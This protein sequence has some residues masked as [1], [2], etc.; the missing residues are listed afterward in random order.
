VT[1]WTF[2]AG[3]PAVR[4]LATQQ[5]YSAVAQ[6]VMQIIIDLFQ[7]DKLGDGRYCSAQVMISATFGICDGVSVTIRL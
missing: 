6:V 5:T 1:F 3:P 2:K 4:L 7:R